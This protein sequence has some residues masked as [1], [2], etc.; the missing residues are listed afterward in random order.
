M[1]FQTGTF[2]GTDTLADVFALLASF[3][4]SNGWT[5][6]TSTGID[7]H[8]SQDEC[9]V[10]L[11]GTTTSTMNDQFGPSGSATAPDHRING[12]LRA[13]ATAFSAADVTGNNGRVVSNDWTPPYANYW[14][15]SNADGEA[16]YIHLVVQRADGRFNHLSFGVVDKKGA[17]YDGGAFLHG[18]YWQ[19]GFSANTASGGA[20]GSNVSTG[21]HLYFGSVNDQINFAGHNVFLGD[22]D[23]DLVINNNTVVNFTRGK[24]APLFAATKSIASHMSSV[25]ARWLGPFFHLGPNPI[26]GVTPLMEVPVMRFNTETSRLQYLGSLPDWRYCSM[27]GRDEGETVNFS[28]DEWM[29]FPLKRALPWN[30]EPFDSKS[31][32]SGPYGVAIKKNV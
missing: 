13:D 25:Q 14:L 6:H 15:F 29:I 12:R 28:S 8:A 17:A 2:D 5:V 7:F 19:W 27:I 30:P 24:I 10:S 23:A 9:H 18:T 3:A 20:N 1:S 31:V 16:P 21:S 11:V 26:N 4:G 22:V 32:T